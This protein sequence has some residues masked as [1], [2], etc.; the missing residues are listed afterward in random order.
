M[1]DS[2]W[3]YQSS[4][5]IAEQAEKLVDEVTQMIDEEEAPDAIITKVEDARKKLADLATE[6]DELPRLT[7]VDEG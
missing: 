6:L 3:A 7:E 5:D 4:K 2:A 1:T